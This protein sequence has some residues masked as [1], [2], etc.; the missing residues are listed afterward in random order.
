MYTHLVIIYWF[1]KKFQNYIMV[2]S[3][4]GVVFRVMVGDAYWVPKDENGT[5][6]F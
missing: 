1:R 3:F 4:K 2:Y 5:V 6:D